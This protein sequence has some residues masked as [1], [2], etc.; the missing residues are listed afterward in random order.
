MQIIKHAIENNPG[1]S[2]IVAGVAGLVFPYGALI[3]NGVLV[4]ILAA[5]IFLSCFRINT[6]LRAVFSWRPLVFCLM[7]Y[8]ALPILLWGICK[9]IAPSYALGILL[10]A[11]CP[12]GTSSAALTGMYDGDVTLAFVI[13]ILS[14][15]ACVFLIPAV[16]G[17]FGH[18]S[19]ALPVFAIL[20]TIVLCI[21]LPG[22]V[23]IP[24]RR[25][26]PLVEYSRIYGR[27]TVVIMISLLVFIALAKSRDYF[28]ANPQGMIAPL[29]LAAV[30][31][32][33]A[34]AFGFVIKTARPERIAYG[35]CS[36]FNNN[37]LGIGLA[38]M[39]FDQKTIALLVVTEIAWSFLPLFVQPVVKRL[40]ENV[41]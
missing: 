2:M 10:L 17:I 38:L 15:I 19:M 31:Y 23:Y 16:T 18:A 5:L 24:L 3:P 22:V 30:F 35:V 29:L 8:V 28:L 6:P 37:G 14:N 4:A 41:V 7:R 9:E 33:I 21:V 11:L 36:A 32:I 12:A 34:I 39:Y 40:P 1:R 20:K 13:T 26:R 25:R 27:L